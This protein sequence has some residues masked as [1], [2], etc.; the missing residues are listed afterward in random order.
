MRL[1]D[2][3]ANRE[4]KRIMEA[5][6]AQGQLGGEAGQAED[7]AAQAAKQA[8]AK[9]PRRRS[10][11]STLA[12][13]AP[14]QEEEVRCR[15]DVREAQ[16]RYMHAKHPRSRANGTPRT[17]KGSRRLQGQRL[18]E[19]AVIAGTV[20]GAPGQ[21]V[22]ARAG[23]SERRN[24]GRRRAGQ[25]GAAPDLQQRPGLQPPGGPGAFDL[26][27]K[28]DDDTAEMFTHDRGLR[29]AS[30]TTSRRTSAP[31]RGTWTR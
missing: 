4:H 21:P 16:R 29:H 28:M 13:E 15:S 23:R 30:R 12:K 5:A 7:A 18:A 31:C 14:A 24:A 11:R 25:E 1:A 10:P 19:A 2:V 3:M 8:T 6:A 27:M 20:A 17:K 22:P 9:E 26:V